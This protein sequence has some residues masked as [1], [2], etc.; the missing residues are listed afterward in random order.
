MKN[1][2]CLR[3]FLCICLLTTCFQVHASSIDVE[4][5]RP[6]HQKTGSITIKSCSFAPF[7]STEKGITRVYK[8]GKFLYSIDK[9]FE[10]YIAVS[11]NGRHFYEIDF[12]ARS[13]IAILHY[14]NGI[15]KDT[16]TSI[17]LGK[18]LNK[19]AEY[20][21]HNEGYHYW[22]KYHNHPGNY[23]GKSHEAGYIYIEHYGTNYPKCDKLQKRNQT[24]DFV[25]IQD[26]TLY[27]KTV[28]D[29]FFFIDL[30]RG[31]FGKKSVDSGILKQSAKGRRDAYR[32]FQKY[33]FLG[34]GKFP[35][36]AKK[37]AS[38]SEL[39]QH[40]AVTDQSLGLTDIKG[41]V[42]LYFILELGQEGY[43]REGSLTI[44]AEN[45]T[46][47]AS[48]NERLLSV[49]KQIKFSTQNIPN[50]AA[51]IQF[52]SWGGITSHPLII[53]L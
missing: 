50:G 8:K 7:R 38:F 21:H 39:I 2:T 41:K 5:G 3:I 22:S 49:L 29:E 30:A 42:K 18:M 23:E 27:I 9:Y 35:A 40:L 44:V 16:F 51:Y 13:K 10:N 37:Y 46:I 15:V 45:H 47:T 48:Q 33:D 12:R 17:E 43:I 28:D 19:H 14:Y 32:V 20:F 25:F 1:D 31:V 11:N 36:P 34:K 52:T 26:D 24:N 53:Q 6:Y 4:L